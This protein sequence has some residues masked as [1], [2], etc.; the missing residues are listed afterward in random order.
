MDL[1]CGL[2]PL[3]PEI[4]QLTRCIYH[5]V[6]PIESLSGFKAFAKNLDSYKW[7]ILGILDNMSEEAEN[8]YDFAVE[9]R[10][11]GDPRYM[12]RLGQQYVLYL[13][14]TG[15]TDLCKEASHSLDIFDNVLYFVD[16]VETLFDTISRERTQVQILNGSFIENRNS[17]ETTEFNS[18]LW[19]L[20]SLSLSVIDLLTDQRVVDAGVERLILELKSVRRHY[21]YGTD[22]PKASLWGPSLN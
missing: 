4:S 6:Q 8:L 3:I 21:Y 5:E 18:H 1:L 2:N 19:I 17:L 13:A 7:E 11:E 15:K 14:N 16:Y 12:I 10:L 22:I 20:R 9:K